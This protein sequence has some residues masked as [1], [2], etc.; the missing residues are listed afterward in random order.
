MTTPRIG[1]TVHYTSHGTP[2]LTDGTRAYTP[3]CRAAI[4][5]A[6]GSSQDD[7]VARAPNR[8]VI[9]RQPADTTTDTADLCVLNPEGMYFNRGIP[10]DTANGWE[11]FTP[12]T[13]HMIH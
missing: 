7:I 12:G 3:L 8:A 6:L 11:D 10:T 5:T 4:I 2:T 1:D 13:W 9:Y